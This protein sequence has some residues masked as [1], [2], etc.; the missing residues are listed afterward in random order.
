MKNET[1]H[2]SEESTLMLQ[3]Q[4]YTILEDSKKH[5]ENLSNWLTYL[6]QELNLAKILNESVT[7]LD[8]EKYLEMLKVM[9]RVVLSKII[10]YHSFHK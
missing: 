10:T 3:K 2:F 9:H 5:T 1:K 8:E 7:Y 6:E 4:L